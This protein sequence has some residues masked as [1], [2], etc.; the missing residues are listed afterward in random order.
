MKQIS[1]HHPQVTQSDILVSNTPD[2]VFRSKPLRTQTIVNIHHSEIQQVLRPRLAHPKTTDTPKD[3]S[4]NFLDH[5]IQEKA[6]RDAERMADVR[7]FSMASKNC[8]I[9]EPASQIQPSQ[10][11][12]Y[13]QKYVMK[14]I[15][16]KMML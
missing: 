7:S 16:T 14:V 5:L 12:K 2:N 1:S 13:A 6:R 15:V 8:A 10:S 11:L 9:Q 4:Y 3:D